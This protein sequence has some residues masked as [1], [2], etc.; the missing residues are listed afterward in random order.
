MFVDESEDIKSGCSITLVR[1]IWTWKLQF[2][3]DIF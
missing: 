2:L 1:F 3:L